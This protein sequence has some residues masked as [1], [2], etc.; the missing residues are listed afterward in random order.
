MVKNNIPIDSIRLI[1]DYLVELESKY[2]EETIY[3][4][5]I[6]ESTYISMLWN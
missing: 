1:V 2:Y 5:I 4:A 3:D 6:K